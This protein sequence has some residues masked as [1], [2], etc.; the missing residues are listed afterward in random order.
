MRLLQ[1]ICFLILVGLGLGYNN[2]ASATVPTIPDIPGACILH[3]PYGDPDQYVKRCKA[4]KIVW[5]PMDASEPGDK[6][7]FVLDFFS[8]P[9]AW[10]KNLLSFSPHACDNS[11]TPGAISA[12]PPPNSNID[13]VF[14]VSDSNGVMS[15]IGG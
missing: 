7:T 5:S 3:S 8:A 11:C 12:L 1:W 9:S 4:P 10:I 2:K 14:P 6:R 15:F 13:Y